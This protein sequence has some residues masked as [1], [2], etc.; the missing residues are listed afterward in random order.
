MHTVSIDQVG[1]ILHFKVKNQCDLELV[2][3]SDSFFAKQL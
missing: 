1:G 3:E 2:A